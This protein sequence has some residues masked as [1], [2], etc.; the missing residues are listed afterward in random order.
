MARR[1]GKSGSA[2]L[3]LRRAARAKKRL[4]AHAARR[5]APEEKPRPTERRRAPGA[6]GPGRRLVETLKTAVLVIAAITVLTILAASIWVAAHAP[7]DLAIWTLFIGALECVLSLLGFAFIFA[8]LLAIEALFDN[9]DQTRGLLETQNEMLEGT[10][11]ETELLAE[12]AAADLPVEEE[13]DDEE[14][15]AGIVAEAEPG[16]TSEEE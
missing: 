11:L 15:E 12:I 16:D 8:L 6:Y 10:R 13:D 9:A 5:P 3:R 1:S 2:A 4:K 14:D 7:G